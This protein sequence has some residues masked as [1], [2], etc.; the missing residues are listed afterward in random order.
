MGNAALD[1]VMQIAADWPEHLQA[2]LA[3]IAAE[4]DAGLRGGVYY[5]TAEEWEGIRRGIADARA[6]KFATP[7]EMA[8][9]FNRYQNAGAKECGSADIGNVG[10]LA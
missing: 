2:E 8:A 9:L 3:E 1:R 4:M 6:G 5:P 7:E 10:N